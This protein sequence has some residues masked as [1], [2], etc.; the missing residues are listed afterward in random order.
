MGRAACSLVVRWTL[1]LCLMITGVGLGIALA[2][3][4]AYADGTPLGK[5]VDRLAGNA[6]KV[7]GSVAKKKAPNARP[8]AVR[9][10]AHR[11]T[12]K[13]AKRVVRSSR[14]QAKP[15]RVVSTPRVRIHAPA[16]KKA[17][18]PV[19]ST[20]KKSRPA[21]IVKKAPAKINRGAKKIDKPVAKK[22]IDQPR[23][24]IDKAAAKVTRPVLEL[25]TLVLPSVEL[26]A[27][28][29]PPVKVPPG[30]IPPVRLPMAPAEVP[31]PPSVPVVTGSVP[32][33]TP[34]AGQPAIPAVDRVRAAAI[35]G[36]TA[37]AATPTPGAVTSGLA[38]DLLRTIV[39]FRDETSAAVT[40]I[41]VGT[42]SALVLAAV[43]G[44]AASSSAGANASGWGGIALLPAALSLS[45]V[46]VRRRF[47]A[48]LRLSAW[49]IGYR[50][51]FA[52]D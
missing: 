19:R 52:P 37:V 3:G 15:H 28:K 41:S 45:A 7:T 44:V 4:T 47:S 16:R 35:D 13:P 38:A 29:L 25:P 2:A 8:K 23:K 17:V 46:G 14:P 49:R 42:S 5:G 24:K 1:R 9:K 6:K 34:L 33:G 51:A 43:I 48:A 39:T 18:S 26:P 30:E 27:I 40:P 32:P 22:K 20:I 11:P 50:P 21:T 12:A 10:P 36:E 31:G